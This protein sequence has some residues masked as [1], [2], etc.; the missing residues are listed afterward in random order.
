MTR[1]QVVDEVSSGNKAYL[2]SPQTGELT[3]PAGKELNARFARLKIR[4]LGDAVL[5]RR[6]WELAARAGMQSTLEAEY[7][8][9][10]QL[11]ADALVTES[12]ALMEYSRGLVPV[13]PFKAL[14][15][16]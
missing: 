7:L 2:V 12:R 5:R 15:R 6:A 9:L 14:T 11:Q 1:Y 4:Y 13:V 8:A 10:K 16:T 3:E